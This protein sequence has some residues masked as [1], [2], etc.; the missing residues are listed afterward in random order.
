LLSSVFLSR[1]S[2]KEK[3]VLSWVCPKTMK[4]I[5]NRKNWKKQEDQYISNHS[6]EDSIK[7]L[8]RS[9]KSIEIRLWRLKNMNNK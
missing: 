4:K 6:I 1:K 5:V 8:N 3:E 9:Q 7:M 2:Q